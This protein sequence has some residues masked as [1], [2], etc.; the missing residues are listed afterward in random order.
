[1]ANSV[2]VSLVPTATAPLIPIFMSTIGGVRQLCVHPFDLHD[3]LET[4]RLFVEWF[5]DRQETYKLV[6]GQDY[7]FGSNLGQDGCARSSRMSLDMAQVLSIIENNEPGYK[8]Y[9]YFLQAKQSFWLPIVLD[10][11]SVEDVERTISNDQADKLK[12]LVDLEVKKRGR[13]YQTVWTDFQQRFGIERYKDLP[14]HRFEEARDYLIGLSKVVEL[15]NN[16]HLPKISGSA[17][18]AT[19]VGATMNQFQKLLEA[20]LDAQRTTLDTIQCLAL[21]LKTVGKV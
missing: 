5:Q 12:K 4:G 2:R 13:H 20:T 18:L 7:I 10:N 11:G 15:P 17:E 3:L 19:D 9:R 1:M 16:I 6:S 21:Q 14:A 8:L